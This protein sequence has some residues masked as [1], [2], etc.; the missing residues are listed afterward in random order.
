MVTAV[1][2]LRSILA[3]AF[4]PLVHTQRLRRYSRRHI[5]TGDLERQDVIRLCGVDLVRET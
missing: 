2:N 4:L 5:R 3:G 1:V